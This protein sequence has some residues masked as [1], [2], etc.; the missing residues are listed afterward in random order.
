[1]SILIALLAGAIS[2]VVTVLLHRSIQ[3][4]GLFLGLAFTLTSLWWVGRETAQKRYK[5]IAS[6]IWFIVLYRAGSFGEGQEILVM[7]DGVGTALFLLGLVTLIYGT[8]RKI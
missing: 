3:P 1:M 2:S 6:A 8:L 5:A 4:W 7:G